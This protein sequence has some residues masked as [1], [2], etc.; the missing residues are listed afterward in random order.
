M[1]FRTLMVHVTPD[2]FKN[3]RID[4]ALGLARQFGAN[5]I[6]VGAMA[7]PEAIVTPEGIM[8]PDPDNIS[9]LESD[10]KA[11][12]LRFAKKTAV[13]GKDK[14]SWR[15]AL[16]A[17]ALFV[18]EQARAVDLVVVS[19]RADK[20]FP[21]IGIDPSDVVM[22][23]LTVP[24]GKGKLDFS[25]VLVAWKDT[26]QARRAVMAALPVLAEAERVVVMGVGDETT[27]EALGDIASWLASHAVTAETVHVNE[28]NA[29]RAIIKA[30]ELQG[31][32]LIVAGA[33][34]RS[35]LREFILG[36]VTRDLLYKNKT[37][38]LFSH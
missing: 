26:P 23:V 6:G 19:A 1:A 27:G 12:S 11:L 21:V 38:C 32:G 2:G 8:H 35:R 10:L 7:R 15:S 20:D 33:Y 36:G 9:M 13:L 25:T 18:A 4:A 37:P 29:G 22:P 3:G 34:G 24:A 14:T 17:P 5:L 31:A 16:A 28:R 30:A